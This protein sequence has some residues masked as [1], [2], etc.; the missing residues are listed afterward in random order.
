MTIS[1][2]ILLR[3]KIFRQ[4]CSKNRNTHLMFSF[5]L[6]E[7]RAVY[8]IMSKNVGETDGPQMRSQYGS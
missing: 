1:Q 7:N 5:F 4:I 3:M 8:E 6:S 2:Y